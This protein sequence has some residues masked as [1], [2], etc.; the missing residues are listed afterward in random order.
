MNHPTLARI[1]TLLS[2]FFLLPGCYQS[3]VPISPKDTIVGKRQYDTPDWIDDQFVYSE[4]G[5]EPRTHSPSFDNSNSFFESKNHPVLAQ[6]F[7]KFD[8]SSI[9]PEERDKLIEVINILNESPDT[10]LLLI[11]H[12]DWHGTHE[13][14]LSL[15]DRRASSVC[16]YIAQCGIEKNRIK[17]LSRGDL[18]AIIQGTSQQRQQD[19]RTDVF[20]VN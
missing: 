11:G 17:T 16:N 2:L 19:R 12:C 14:N 9:L 1:L 13:Y 8:N 18:D 6:V 5:L 15:G 20:L 7:F 10:S 3:E 4:Q